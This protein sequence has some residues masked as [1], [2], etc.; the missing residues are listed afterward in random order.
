MP[1]PVGSRCAPISSA[2]QHTALLTD[3]SS[4]FRFTS[5][6]AL[7]AEVSIAVGP[8]GRSGAGAVNAGD[9]GMAASYAYSHSRGFFAGVSMEGSVIVSR[10]FVNKKFYG[11]DVLVRD[12]LS[13]AVP[14]PPAAEPLYEALRKAFST[15]VSLQLATV[16]SSARHFAPPHFV[17]CDPSCRGCWQRTLSS[18]RDIRL[19]RNLAACRRE[20]RRE[21]RK[22]RCSK[23]AS[24]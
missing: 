13:G 17:L 8:L 22:Q 19:R 12:L 9:G 7:G 23:Q 18:S 10:P 15:R 6:F 21:C 14:S 4:I 16:L 2:S 5:K 20:C 24:G 11:K 1:S 3:L